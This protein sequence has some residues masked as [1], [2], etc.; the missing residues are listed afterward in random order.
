MSRVVVVGSLN[1][2]LIT[3][4][5]HLP[6]PGET[7]LGGAFRQVSGGKGGNQAHAAV[8]V[9]RSR[10]EQAGEV[11]VVMIGRVGEDAAANRLCGDLAAAGVDVSAV[12]RSRNAASGIALITV[13]ADGANT[14][15]VAPGANYDWPADAMTEV[16]FEP[17]DVVVTQLEVPLGVVHAVAGAARAAGARF[18]LNAA[19]ADPRV[20]E[21]L[22]RADVVVLNEIEAEQLLE[23]R[24]AE[25]DEIGA[26]RARLD[27]DLVVTLGADGAVVAARDGRTVHVPGLAVDAIDTVGAGDAFVGALAATLAAGADVVDAAAT[28]NAVGAITATVRGARHPGLADALGAVREVA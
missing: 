25:L 6:S 1:L 2:D 18:V 3:E 11:A 15:V 9:A 16:S 13:A 17:D 19:P 22:S 21:V 8:G 26:A 7:I 28:A 12:G 20:I 27:G 23:I 14:I 4:V 5:D 24:T 10:V